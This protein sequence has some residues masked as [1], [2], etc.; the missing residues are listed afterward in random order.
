MH[1]LEGNVSEHVHT[2]NTC[3]GVH[4]LAFSIIYGYICHLVDDIE[5]LLQQK[6][7]ANAQLR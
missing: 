2:C 7:E 1:C 4:F 6:D 3:T 5:A